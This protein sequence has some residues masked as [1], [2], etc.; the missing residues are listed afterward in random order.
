MSNQINSVFQKHSYIPALDG[1][2]AIA[3]LLVLFSHC[4]IY[5]Q[6]TWLHN[7]GKELGYLGVSIFFVLSGYLITRLLI[8]EEERFESISL[9]NFYIRRSFRLLPALWI[10]LLVVFFLWLKGLLPNNPWH[11]FVTSVLYIRNLIGHGSAT[12]HLWSLSVEEQ[13]YFL[14]PIIL[15]IFS[16]Q[17]YRRLIFVLITIFIIVAWRFYAIT[18][19][20]ASFGDIYI[21]TDFRLDS[22]LLGCALALIERKN[23]ISSLNSSPFL[24]DLWLVSSTFLIGCWT[25]IQLKFGNFWGISSTLVSLLGCILIYS[26]IYSPNGFGNKILASPPLVFIGKI[27]YGLYLW[28]ALFLYNTTLEPLGFLRVFPV[29]L[30]LTFLCGLTSYFVIEKPFLKIKDKN[31]H[32]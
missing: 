25:L 20:L 28:Q 21:R 3:I 18:H 15:I 6:F 27:S 30:L 17:N 19:N 24:S 4:V 32:R 9:K 13:F 1:I 23:L 22:P 7:I 31:F 26:Q 12:D 5:D 10:Y 11:S 16:K 8:K 2:R 29:N 14:W